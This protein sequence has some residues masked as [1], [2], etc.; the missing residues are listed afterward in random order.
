MSDIAFHKLSEEEKLRLS[1]LF[2]SLDVNGDGRIDVTDLTKALKKMQ[3]P[4]IPGQAQVIFLFIF[5]FFLNPMTL[6]LNITNHS[7]QVCW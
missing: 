4:Q 6:F 5:Y 7:D 2:K 1:T 3:V